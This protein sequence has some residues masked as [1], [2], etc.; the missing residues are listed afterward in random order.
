MTFRDKVS[1]C[2]AVVFFVLFLAAACRN[3]TPKQVHLSLRGEACT[4]VTVTWVTRDKEDT[5]THTVK[6]GT[7][8]GEYTDETEGNSHEIPNESVG[9]VHE[10]ELRNL[11][12]NTRYYYI[13]GEKA[14]EWSAEYTF[15]TAP[16][17]PQDCSFV[18]IGDMGTTRAAKQNL[19]QMISENPSFV[20]HTGDLSYANGVS[21]LWDVWFNQIVPL[22]S[23]VPYMPSIGNHEVEGDLGLSSYLG[24][25]ALPNN[26]RWYSFDWG[27]IHVVS[28]DTESPH[29]PDSDQFVWLES[30]L[31][32]AHGDSDIDWIVVFFHKPPYSSSPVHGS[33][34]SV[35]NSICPILDRYEVDIVFNG[36]DHI[37]ER[38]HPL[39]KGK[40]VDEG[41]T[42]YVVTGGGGYS[43]YAVGSD[44]WTA[45]SQSIFHHVKV[46]ITAGKKLRLQAISRDGSVFDEFQISKTRE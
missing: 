42:I 41:G 39:E 13:C 17:T 40:I 23:S 45:H 2:K 27:N 12:P 14:G 11:V 26:E 15:K 24:R 25:F 46:H 1:R 6:Y 37:Y 21:F 18:V 43:L 22:A 35:R 16:K 32:A 5:K 7:L 28:L 38:S 33:N 36:H 19:D 9:Y 44:Y 34:L 8:P 10:V 29:T 31:A 20:L 3:W 4:S 30:D